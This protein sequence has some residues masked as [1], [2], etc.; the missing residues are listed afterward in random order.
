MVELKDLRRTYMEQQAEQKQV[1]RTMLEEV[2]NKIEAKHKQR[3]YNMLYRVPLVV[4]GNPHYNPKT[5]MLY[6]VKKL[7]KKEFV[8]FPYQDNLVYIDWSVVKR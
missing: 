4:F 3:Q 5:C 7:T 2:F 6:I 8:V 1:Y